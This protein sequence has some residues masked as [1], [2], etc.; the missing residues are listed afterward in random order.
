MK[1]YI[2]IW[3]GIHFLVITCY[4]Q[5]AN[6][7]AKWTLKEVKMFAQKYNLQDSITETKNTALLKWDK[8]KIDLWCQ[9][10]AKAI[11]ERNQIDAYFRDTEKVKSRADYFKLLDSY[12]VIKEKIVNSHGGK[13]GFE[14]FREDALKS[15][16][17][18][19]RNSK[20]A[21]AFRPASYPISQEEQLLGKRVDD[22]PK[23]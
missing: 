12:P 21:L 10:W 3:I 7:T 14:K 6:S 20:G 15:K 13:I 22:L 23:D 1:K 8:T 4:G 9:N 17:R 2:I 11:N 19:Y 16:C 5:Q 18:I